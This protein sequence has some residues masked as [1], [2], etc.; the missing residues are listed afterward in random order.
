MYFSLTTRLG[1]NRFLFEI[2]FFFSNHIILIIQSLKQ[3]LVLYCND[4][5]KLHTKNEV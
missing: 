4:L 2:F 3:N 5:Y 1:P